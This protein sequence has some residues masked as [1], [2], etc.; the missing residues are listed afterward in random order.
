MLNCRVRNSDCESPAHINPRRAVALSLLADAFDASRET[1]GDPWDFALEISSLL[2]AGLTVNDLRWL[3][4]M[5]YL[6]HA[7]E[8]TRIEDPSRT[9]LPSHNLGFPERTCFV[10]TEAGLR[11]AQRGDEQVSA[12]SG[13]IQCFSPSS[14]DERLVPSWDRQRRVLYFGD[15][16][17]KRF[18]VPSPSQET[19]LMAFEEER[20]RAAID[21]PLPP[22]PEQDSKRRLRATLQSLNGGQKNRLIRFRGDGSGER[23]VWELTSVAEQWPAVLPSAG[24]RAA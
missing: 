9:F 17:V 15:I 20:W 11:A 12:V 24:Q 18:R 1:G 10:A 3:S 21:D 23:I 13:P 14:A 16:I 7:V 6:Q 5:G 8:A 19:I 4:A 22:Q 2:S